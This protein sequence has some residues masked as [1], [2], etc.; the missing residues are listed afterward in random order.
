MSLLHRNY[1]PGDEVR[2]I[3]LFRLSFNREM[4]N[5][6]WEWRYKDNTAA[7][8]YIRLAFDSET[9]AAHYA[10]SPSRLY[11][12]GQVYQSA[13]SMTT[14]THP[15]YRGLKLFTTLA[16]ELF[17]ENREA[18]DVVYGVPNEN[19]LKGFVQYLDFKLIAGIKMLE[20]NYIPG[21]GYK[22]G[23]C[24]KVKAFDSRF[25]KLMSEAAKRYRIIV[26]RDSAY[27]NW[28]FFS[29]PQNKY[30]V[31]SYE[32]N[33]EILGYVVTKKYRA[34]AS[35]TG[36]I[37]DVLAVNS[38]VFVKLIGKVIGEFNAEGITAIKTWMNDPE[39]LKVLEKLGFRE[40]EESHHFIV[41]NNS[42]RLPDDIFDFGNWY[43][44]MGDIDIF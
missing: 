9:M 29:N 27:L 34:A 42:G 35:L 21:K 39:L 28:R 32:E 41:R 24:R 11:V 10:L 1:K 6:F 30:T 17:E 37:V 4:E 20:L 3:D 19:S 7:G 2:I 15:E 43:I 26:A 36:D 33:G 16:K 25:D 13:L 44:T 31:Y 14:M 8:K 18:L 38:N 23:G 40:T 5:A 22:D 12:N